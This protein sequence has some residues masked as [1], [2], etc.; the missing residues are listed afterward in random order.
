MSCD[1][2]KI[3]FDQKGIKKRAIQ[4]FSFNGKKVQ[5]VHVKGEECLVARDAY[6]AIAYEEKN[7][8]KVIQNLVPYK[9]KLGLE[10]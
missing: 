8:K 3:F 2:I 4:Q 6:E 1:W 10:T 7:R 9:D 5:S